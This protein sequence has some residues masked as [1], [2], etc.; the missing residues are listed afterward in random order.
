M[1]IDEYQLCNQPKQGSPGGRL[2][3]LIL[4]NAYKQNERNKMKF[5]HAFAGCY[6]VEDREQ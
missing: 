1:R 4:L 6:K 5:W 2:W 3:G